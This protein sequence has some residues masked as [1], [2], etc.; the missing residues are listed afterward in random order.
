MFHIPWRNDNLE[1]TSTLANASID[2]SSAFSHT[3]SIHKTTTNKPA[4]NLYD[5]EQE[6]QGSNHEIALLLYSDILH[7]ES[8]ERLTVAYWMILIF[9]R[10]HYNTYIL[11]H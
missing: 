9:M 10:N 3:T 4:H 7:Y 11:R 8:T 5:L 6:G 2:A 1:S